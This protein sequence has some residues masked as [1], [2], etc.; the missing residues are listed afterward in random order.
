MPNP[1]GL[2]A[3][4]DPTPR[5]S[6]PLPLSGDEV[7]TRL[8]QRDSP[9]TKPRSQFRCRGCFVGGEQEVRLRWQHGK[10]QRGG[11]G[12]PAPDATRLDDQQ[13]GAGGNQG[14]NP[15]HLR[16]DRPHASV[17]ARLGHSVKMLL[18]KYAR[19]IPGKDDWIER[20][21]LEAAMGA[22]SSPETHPGPSFRRERWWARLDSNQRPSPCKGCQLA[23]PDND[24]ARFFGNDFALN[25]GHLGTLQ[26]SVIHL[27]R[28]TEHPAWATFARRQA[29]R[30]V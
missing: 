13:I 17:A 8:L 1:L 26:S 25:R 5:F 24:L 18:E 2:G 12:V 22:K 4:G 11:G 23:L 3:R 10:T 9:F 19:W 20:R 7:P 21:L 29:A 15:P 6:A 28:A 27:A 30:I 14:T 16:H